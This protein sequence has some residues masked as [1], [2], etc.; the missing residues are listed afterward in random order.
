M[1]SATDVMIR[2]ADTL[3]LILGVWCVLRG[4]ARV[5]GYLS[6]FLPDVID[7]FLWRGFSRDD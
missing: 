3:L 7:D 6:K 5:F 2:L 1:V 4:L